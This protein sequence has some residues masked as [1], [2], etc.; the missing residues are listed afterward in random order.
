MRKLILLAVTL[1]VLGG[2]ASR[3]PTCDGTDRRPVNAPVQTGTTYPSC[4]AAA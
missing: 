4:G 2:C 1:A 3:L